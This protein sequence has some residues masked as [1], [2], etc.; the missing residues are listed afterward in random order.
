VSRDVD[1]LASCEAA[2]RQAI[3]DGASV[4]RSQ[5]YYLDVTPAGTDKGTVVKALIRRLDIPAA[6]IVSIGDMDND[7]PMFRESGFSIAMGNASAEVRRHADAVTLSNEAD[8]FAH[9]V[10]RHILPRTG[11][12]SDTGER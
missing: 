8:G 9:A 4:A 12:P 3:G 11:H 7:V 6:E 10:A 2:V 1:R 5:P